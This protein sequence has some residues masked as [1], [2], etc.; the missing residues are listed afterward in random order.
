MPAVAARGRGR[1]TMSQ[2]NMVPFIDVMLVLLIIFMVT[3]TLIVPGQIELPGVGQAAR[4]PERFIHVVIDAQG[5]I[6]LRDSTATG[7]A[8]ALTL[9]QLPAR[10]LALQAAAA[11]ASADAADAATAPAPAAAPVIISADRSLRYE[12]VIEAMDALQRAG[13]ARIG[14]AVQEATP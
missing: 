9:E 10:V 8:Q 11:T 13:V 1:R 7:P 3:A 2:I 14:L 5:Q 12:T 6:E 4:Q